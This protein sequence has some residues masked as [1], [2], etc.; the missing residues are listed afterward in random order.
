MLINLYNEKLQGKLLSFADDIALFS[1][2]DNLLELKESMHGDKVI[3]NKW[4]TQY[5]MAMSP[6]IKF[7]TFCVRGKFVLFSLSI[8]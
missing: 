5:F 8:P 7:I 2:S 6:E 1:Q 4:F 3:L